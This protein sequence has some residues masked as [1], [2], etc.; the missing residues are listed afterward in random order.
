M[1]QKYKERKS[2]SKKEQEEILRMAIREDK[3]Q[4]EIAKIVGHS[5]PSVSR[6]INNYKK[7]TPIKNLSEIYKYVADCYDI[8][9]FFIPINREV[10]ILKRLL[11]DKYSIKKAPNKLGIVHIEEVNNGLLIFSTDFYLKNKILKDILK[12]ENDK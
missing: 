4:T 1:K 2:I 12:T 11:M 5:Q 10:D 3:T 8:S 6:I 7:R 9:S